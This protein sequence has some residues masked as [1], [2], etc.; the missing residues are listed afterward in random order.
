MVLRGRQH[1]VARENAVK[2][3][4]ETLGCLVIP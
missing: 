4:E 3:A 1:D 2:L